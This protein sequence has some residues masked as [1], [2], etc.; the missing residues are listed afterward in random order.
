MG[1]HF[2]KGGSN[3]PIGIEGSGIGGSGMG[4]PI[5]PP[6]G[7]GMGAPI[8]DSGRGSAR[9]TKGDPIMLGVVSIEGISGTSP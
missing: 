4:G 6:S 8:T 7:D 1:G 2:G 3:G 9:G 5:G